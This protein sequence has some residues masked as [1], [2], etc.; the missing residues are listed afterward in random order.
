MIASLNLKEAAALLGI[1]HHTLQARA[2]A[3][4]IP[5]AKIGKQWR[6][7][8]EDLLEYLR[9]QYPPRYPDNRK[10]KSPCR[11]TNVGVSGGRTLLV[12]D[13]EFVQ[14]LALPTKRR[15]SNSTTN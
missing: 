3:G 4:Q 15:H 7:L 13:A 12:E 1:H 6:F 11:F 10:E 5:G 2:R 14:A 8:E 9:S